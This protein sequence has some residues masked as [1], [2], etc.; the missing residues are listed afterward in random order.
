MKNFHIVSSPDEPSVE[1]TPEVLFAIS[2]ELSKDEMSESERIKK[3]SIPFE[4]KLT[5]ITDYIKQRSLDVL[6]GDEINSLLKEYFHVDGAIKLNKEDINE[7]TGLFVSLDK[8]G[9][10]IE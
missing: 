5:G 3:L 9:N 1:L 7:L 8:D 2:D 6:A 4:N 10:P